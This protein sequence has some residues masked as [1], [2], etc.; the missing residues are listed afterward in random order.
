[1]IHQGYEEKK[2]FISL[3]EKK[4]K[5]KTKSFNERHNKEVERNNSYKGMQYDTNNSRFE[6]K[7][8]NKRKDLQSAYEFKNNFKLHVSIFDNETTV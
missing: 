1:M 6:N 4:N 7:N 3:N 5:K 8:R 2:F